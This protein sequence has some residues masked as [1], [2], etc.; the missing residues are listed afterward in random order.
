MRITFKEYLV[1]IV[2]LFRLKMVPWQE[3]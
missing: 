1:D 2:E 3:S